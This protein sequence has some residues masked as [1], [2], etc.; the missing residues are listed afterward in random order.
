[1]KKTQQ[2]F[3]RRSLHLALCAALAAP[4]MAQ[5]QQENLEGEGFVLNEVIVTGLRKSLEDASLFKRESVNFTDAVFSEDVGKF[6]DLNIAEAINRIPG[7]QLTRE[8]DGSGVN[9]A[10][11]GLN[12]NFT[13]VTLNG[14]QIAVASSGKTDAIN[15]N[16]ELDL[17][18]FPTEFF[19][20]LDVSKTTTA[21]MVEG[22]LSG[23]VNM[24]TLRPMDDLNNYLSFQLQGGYGELSEKISPSASLIGSW[25]NSDRSF[26]VLA[27]FAAVNNKVVTR[28]Y[29]T[30]GWTN[31]NLTYDQ[32]GAM[33]DTLP[34]LPAPNCSGNR[35]GGNQFVIGQPVAVDPATD[36]PTGGAAGYHVVPNNTQITGRSGT[37]YGP[38]TRIDR[39]FLLDINPGLTTEQIGEALIPRMGRPHYSEGDRDRLAGVLSMEWIPNEY[40]NYYL[41]VLYAKADR[42]YNRLSMSMLGRNSQIIPANM[43]VDRN[44]IVTQA[45]LYNAQFELEARPYTETLDFVSINPGARF[46]LGE[47]LIIDAQLHATSSDW[48]RESP[49]LAFHTNLNG[50]VAAHFRN[51]GGEYPTLWPNI[52]LNDPNQVA[53]WNVERAFVQLEERET[54]T[55]GARLDFILGEDLTNIKFGLSYDQVE[56]SIAGRDNP[57][58]EQHVMNQVPDST[59]PNYLVPGPGGFVMLDYGRFFAATDYADYLANAQINT[60]SNTGAP[61][62]SIDESAMAA[63]VEGNWQKYFGTR[64]LRL[65][66]G[67]RYVNT[68][69][70]VAGVQRQGNNFLFKEESHDYENVLPALN[71]AYELRDDL[72]L[73]SALSRTMTRPNP[74]DMLPGFIFVDPSG[75]YADEGNPYLKPYTSDNFDLGVEWY[76]NDEGYASANYF[77]KRIEGFTSDGIRSVTVNQLLGAMQLSYLYLS[78]SQRDAIDQR[79]GPD[80]AEVGITKEYNNGAKLNLQG[81]EL[82]WVQPLPMVLEGL[83]YAVTLTHVEQE[84]DGSGA[85]AYATEVSKNTSNL[86]AYYENE[87][88][89]LRLSYVWYDEQY[90][91]NPGQDN[92]AHAQRFIDA[93]GQW[94]FSASY[95]LGSLPTS[96]KITLNVINFGSDPQRETF[97]ADNVAYRYY[98]PGYTVI[99]GFR[100]VLN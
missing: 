98:D 59:L 99:L 15:S 32:C 68:E 87:A 72:V 96:P 43:Q 69:Q 95:N 78:P 16:R 57:I 31:A 18:V 19:R 36:L 90:G 25:K 71:L 23:T 97:I 76:F 85:P 24:R 75:L 42:E 27:G 3:V 34:G 61:T 53:G 92:I 4:V 7:I 48:S 54:D 1:M 28:G 80:R 62:G 44:N 66:A 73:R 9:V 83:G 20:R 94:D 70:S 58:W 52:D 29:E 100:G 45:D 89:S 41:D 37:V 60:T 65:N 84:Q 30:E 88:L 86:T 91:S 49:S 33:T 67:L 39:D 64:S 8:I 47:S 82:L 50:G 11:R 13:K 21:S 79:G 51:S 40:G 5:A 56:R 2:T 14:S 93:R 6:P 26:G 38:G 55:L 77:R 63:Y 46:F 10:I 81:V 74:A 17:D 12:T 35:R 22:G